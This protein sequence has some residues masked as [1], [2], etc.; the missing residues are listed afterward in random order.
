MLPK[1]L[2]LLTVRADGL[3]CIMQFVDFEGSKVLD[4]TILRLRMADNLEVFHFMLAADNGVK[5]IE[6]RN[7]IR[8]FKL[9]HGK[10]GEYKMTEDF[11]RDNGMILTL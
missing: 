9:F 1:C 7:V 4:S 6:K 11:V 5:L 8:R 10:R 2:I 3:P